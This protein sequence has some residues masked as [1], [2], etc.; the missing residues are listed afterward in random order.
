MFK[1]ISFSISEKNLELNRCSFSL[2][3]ITTQILNIP[4]EE[5]AKMYRLIKLTCV[6]FYK[7]KTPP[8]KEEWYECNKKMM[9]LDELM[10]QYPVLSLI[11]GKQQILYQTQAYLG[12]Y[13][14]FG[15]DYCEISESEEL[16]REFLFKYGDFIN[17]WV[18]E[19]LTDYQPEYEENEEVPL[20]SLIFPG[21][22]QDKWEYYSGYCLRYMRVI[23]DID[24]FSRTI[25]NFIDMYLS[26]LETLNRN[27]YVEALSDF[28]YGEEAGQLIVNPLNSDGL[29]ARLDDMKIE[30]IPRETNPGSNKFKIYTCYEVRSFQALLK[31][32]F[33]RAL[34]AGYLIRKCEYC[35]RY[36]LLKNGYHT[37]YCDNPA[38]DNP[39]RTCAQMGYRKHGIKET[40]ADNPKLQSL[41]K[42]LQRIQKDCE[43]NNITDSEKD[44]LS[45]T[46]KDMYHSATVKSGISND[47][48][49]ESLKSK[50]LYSKCGIKRKSKKRGRP[51]K[52]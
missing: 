21:K 29:Y 24:W 23:L 35:G 41:N 4:Q 38:P 36:F 46:A 32:D 16:Y 8:S 25:K 17:E 37:K 3:E 7:N 52:R 20:E 6:I 26:Q 11:K 19:D 42:C 50:N 44:L 18:S 9:E 2:G 27:T 5:F 39:K 33:Y 51:K 30:Y 14:L 45:R 1:T 34:E 15:N 12:Q 28:L 43:R 49:D 47:E 48:F 10:M 40:A 31:T 22:V 13:N